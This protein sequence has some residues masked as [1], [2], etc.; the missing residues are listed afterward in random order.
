VGLTPR[1]I[2]RTRWPGPSPVSS[3]VRGVFDR[4]EDS[5]EAGFVESDS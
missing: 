4:F 5:M 3:Y 1:S 2:L